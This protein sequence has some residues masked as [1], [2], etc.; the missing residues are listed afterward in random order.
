[1]GESLAQYDTAE[2]AEDGSQKKWA[3]WF[4]SMVKSFSRQGSNTDGAVA[5]F[6]PQTKFLATKG[7]VWG[8]ETWKKSHGSIHD[9]FECNAAATTYQMCTS[10]PRVK[11]H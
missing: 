10:P 6:M 3:G 5:E 4:I 11:V 2:L 1:V 7:L 8:T 9:S